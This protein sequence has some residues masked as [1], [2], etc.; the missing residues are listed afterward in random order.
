MKEHPGFTIPIDAW[1]MV[2]MQNNMLKGI[3]K[4]DRVKILRSNLTILDRCQ[5]ARVPVIATKF[6]SMFCSLSP[7]HYFIR[8][9]LVFN[10]P[11][12]V[13]LKNG[14]DAFSRISKSKEPLMEILE[15][16]SVHTLGVSG[17]N[18]TQCVGRTVDGAIENG[19]EVVTALQLL[20]DQPH[21]DEYAV[22]QHIDD[23]RKKTTFFEDYCDLLA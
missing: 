16:H 14:M 11:Y 17:M 13:L 20:A 22:V 10:H 19:F 9:K 1:L 2:D 18:T 21:R 3:S 15:K 7:I 23:F 12:F 4:L 5:R 6:D 8:M